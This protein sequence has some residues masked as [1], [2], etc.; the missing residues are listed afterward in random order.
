MPQL[1]MI[2]L[3]I[4]GLFAVFYISFTLGYNKGRKRGYAEGEIESL[5]ILREKNLLLGQC[6][7][8]G[9]KQDSDNLLPNYGNLDTEDY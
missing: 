4:L 2:D 1:D 6:C 7:L 5:L 8:C 9:L 3:I